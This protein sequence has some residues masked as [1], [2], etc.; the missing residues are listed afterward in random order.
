MMGG[1][2]MNNQTIINVDARG[3]T[4]TPAD[5]QAGVMAGLRA[6]GL[7]A[8]VRVRMGNV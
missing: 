3:S 1:N 6:E 8:D 4:M 5:V 2:T 7:M